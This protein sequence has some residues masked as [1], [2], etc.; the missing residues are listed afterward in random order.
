MIFRCVDRCPLGARRSSARLRAWSRCWRGRS[1]APRGCTW[2]AA[3][4][5]DAV[6]CTAGPTL[7]MTG[8]AITLRGCYL[9]AQCWYIF[10]HKGLRSYVLACVL[11]ICS[12]TSHRTAVNGDLRCTKSSAPGCLMLLQAECYC[13]MDTCGL[14]AVVLQISGSQWKWVCQGQQLHAGAPKVG[15]FLT[16]TWAPPCSHWLTSSVA[17]FNDFVQAVLTV[18]RQDG[19]SFVASKADLAPVVCKVVTEVKVDGQ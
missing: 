4:R 17:C 8:T 15:P 1:A 3:C 13:I 18:S 6:L 12:C 19:H 7:G 10:G 14:M 16:W 11:L 9:P 5:T 2:P